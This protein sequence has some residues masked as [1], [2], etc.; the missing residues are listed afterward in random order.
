MLEFLTGLC[1]RLRLGPS[2][3]M[4]DD[5]G[6]KGLKGGQPLSPSYIRWG[7]LFLLSSCGIWLES[8]LWALLSSLSFSPHTLLSPSSAFV[9]ILSCLFASRSDKMII[10]KGSTKQSNGLCLYCSNVFAA[11]TG[12]KLSRHYVRIMHLPTLSSRLTWTQTHF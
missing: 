7:L 10:W 11:V 1:L 6:S 8:S 4:L 12:W 2:I 3:V 9:F 5:K